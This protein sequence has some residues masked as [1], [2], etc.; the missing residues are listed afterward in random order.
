MFF[1]GELTLQLPG[2]HLRPEPVLHKTST[3]RF[4]GEGAAPVAGGV[5]Y[6]SAMTFSTHGT[7]CCSLCSEGRDA[8][9]N[10]DGERER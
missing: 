1:T 5:H 8:E 10:A 3:S 6:T 7:T 2:I 4:V 9:P